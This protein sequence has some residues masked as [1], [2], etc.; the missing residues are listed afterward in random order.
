MSIQLG[1]SFR[2]R[3]RGAAALMATVFLLLIMAMLGG[4]GLRLSGTDIRDTALQNDSVEALFLA[5]SGLEHAMQRL[6]A[7]VACMSLTPEAAFSLGRGEFQVQSAATVSGLCRVQVVGRVLIAGTQSPQRVIEADIQQAGG[8]TWAVG[9]NGTILQWNG[10]AWVASVSGTANTLNGVSCASSNSCW[11]V[12]TGGT[13]L[14]WDGTSWSSYNTG[15]PGNATLESVACVANSTDDCIAVGRTPFIIWTI[16]IVYRYS[17][18]TWGALETTWFNPGYTD[19]TCSANMCYAVGPGGRVGRGSGGSWTA[20]EVSNTTVDL[21]G[22]DCFTD[23]DCWAVGPNQ[24]NSFFYDRRTAGGWAPLLINDPGDRRILYDVSCPA[25]NDCWAVGERRAGNRYTTT[26]W[27][28]TNWTANF[29]SINGADDLYDIDCGSESDCWTVGAA[30]DVL[31][32]DGTTWSFVA[33]GTT[34]DLNGIYVPSGGGG[35]LSIQRWREI[36]L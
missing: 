22:V 24:G 8:S 25:T 23:N 10:T 34:N 18:G 30:G 32:W 16:G 14:H 29:V 31:R 19:A 35:T 9:N 6:K 4:I 15:L 17:G 27:N 3:Q 12:G 20:P 28:G 11:A 21:H 13:A 36:I 5:E 7:G 1:K 2:H 26:H 33:S